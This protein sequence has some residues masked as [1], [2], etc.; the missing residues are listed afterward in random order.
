M[1]LHFSTQTQSKLCSMPPEILLGILEAT[2]KYLD[3]VKLASTCRG[4][5]DLLTPEVYY[6]V[7]KQL[8]WQPMFEAAQDGNCRTP[9]RCIQ[10]GAP[11]YY[12]PERGRLRSPEE[13]IRCYRP[14]TVK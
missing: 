7:G 4:L 3:K 1:N 6:D 13:A 10:A 5:Y 8:D 9:A 12:R 14:L 2:E 11:I